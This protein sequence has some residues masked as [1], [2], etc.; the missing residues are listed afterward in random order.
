MGECHTCKAVRVGFEP[1]VPFQVHRISSAAP[2]TT[3]PPHRFAYVRRVI[4]FRQLFLLIVKI[5]ID[6]KAINMM[7]APS[8]WGGWRLCLRESVNQRRSVRT[9]NEQ[10]HRETSRTDA[11]STQGTAEHVL[12]CP[13]PAA[14]SW[15]RS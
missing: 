14:H 6:K 7:K 15:K 5:K 2:S 8:P 4:S 11:N 1:T 13:Q 10:E 9:T 3:Q 12:K